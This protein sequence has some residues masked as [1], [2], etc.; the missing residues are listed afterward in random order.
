MASCCR[1][2][3]ATGG[4]DRGAI[5]GAQEGIAE[6]I[7]GARRVRL[8]VRGSLVF[9][10]C[11]RVQRPVDVRAA[12]MSQRLARWRDLAKGPMHRSRVG[13]R[14]ARCWRC[15]GLLPPALR[16]HRHLQEHS[17]V[18]SRRVLDAHARMV[19]GRLVR[20]RVRGVRP[21]RLALRVVAETKR[22]FG[23]GKGEG[24]RGGKKT[25]RLFF[26]GPQRWAEPAVKA[27]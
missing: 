26:K 12:S 17:Y 20:V 10:L 9:I 11:P 1:R 14:L 6:C 16:R 23:A 4:C 25:E 8:F 22:T 3:G 7:A 27:A 13:V 21:C 19:R 24:S 5:S 2:V 15:R 18:R